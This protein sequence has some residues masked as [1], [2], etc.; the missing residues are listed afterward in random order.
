MEALESLEEL[1]DQVRV[2][3]SAEEITKTESEKPIILNPLPGA[4]TGSCGS[5]MCKF[6]PF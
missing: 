6:W 1:A 3:K 5:A 4:V 2:V